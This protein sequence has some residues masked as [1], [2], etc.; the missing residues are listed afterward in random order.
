MR[1]K[2]DLAN[3]AALVAEY[4]AHIANPDRK[5][6]QTGRVWLEFFLE[7]HGIIPSARG[8]HLGES[9]ALWYAILVITKSVRRVSRLEVKHNTA[10]PGRTT[11]RTIRMC[12]S[13]KA[14]IYRDNH[15]AVLLREILAN[16]AATTAVQ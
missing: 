2:Y 11:E 13:N 10:R 8:L 3:A 16:H 4:E 1:T 12:L 7:K 14:S 15:S 9:H 5:V 6:G